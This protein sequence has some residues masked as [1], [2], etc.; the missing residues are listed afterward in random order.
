MIIEIEKQIEMK[1]K[2]KIY[3][4]KK[5]AKHQKYYSVCVLA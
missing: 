1:D 4:E 3:I 5:E 2:A